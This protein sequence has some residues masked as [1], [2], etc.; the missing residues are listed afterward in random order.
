MTK[1]DSSF[2]QP[3]GLTIS[4]EHYIDMRIADLTHYIDGLFSEE[5]L[6][7]TVRAAAVTATATE[8]KEKLLEMNQFRAQLDTERG[9]YITQPLLDAR[10]NAQH[11]EANAIST[12]NEQ[13]IRV[14][15]G[16]V[17]NYDGRL[18]MVGIGWTILTVVVGIVLHFLP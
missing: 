17:A 14:L 12:A 7:D 16:R 8:L 11:T 13:R 3:P 4:L 15:E 6:L 10:L 5:K 2:S 18:L 1:P 9:S